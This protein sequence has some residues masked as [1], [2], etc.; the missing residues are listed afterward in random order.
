M[1]ITPTAA[2]L[3]EMLRIGPATLHEAQD[4]KGTMDGGIKPLDPL[5]RMIGIARTVEVKAG[6]ILPILKALENVKPGEVLVVDGKGFSEV[7]LAGE[8]MAHQALKSG[9]AGMVIDGAV[10]DSAD[11]VRL[12]FPIFCRAVTMKGPTKTQ[13]GAIGEP[14][15]CGGVRVVPGDIVVGDR[16]GVIVVDAGGWQGVLAAARERDAREAEYRAGIAQGR[17]LLRM[18]GLDKL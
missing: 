8:L 13:P 4:Q 17:T 9:L 16:D 10:R 3:Q 5:T 12:K 1:T 15:G 2:E 14:I 11:I 18:H 7:A 6:D